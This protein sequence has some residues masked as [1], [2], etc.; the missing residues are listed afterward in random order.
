MV[1]P[2]IPADGTLVD[3]VVG[4]TREPAAFVAQAFVGLVQPDVGVV[5]TLGVVDG[6]FVGTLVLVGVFVAVTFTTDWHFFTIPQTPP[7][8]LL[9][10]Q[11]LCPLG[12]GYRK[13][14]FLTYE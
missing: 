11:T 7:P 14:L 2:Q 1:S 6:V 10:S 9:P 13:G 8:S 5:V 4:V 3:V 12:S